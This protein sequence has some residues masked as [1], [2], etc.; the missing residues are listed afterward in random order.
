M[1]SQISLALLA[2]VL[3]A[4]LHEPAVAQQSPGDFSGQPASGQLQARPYGCYNLSQMSG[5]VPYGANGQCPPNTT[6]GYGQIENPSTQYTNLTTI[7]SS[8]APL[9]SLS[10]TGNTPSASGSTYLNY[11]LTVPLSDFATASSVS[12]LG[13]QVSQNQATSASSVAVETTRATTAEG[14]IS[15][16]LSAEVTR[17]TTSEAALGANLAAETS[18]ATVAENNLGQLIANETTAREADI[19]RVSWQFRSATASAVALSGNGFIPGKQFNLTINYGAYQGESSVAVQGAY[20]VNP[21]AYLN[22]GVASGLSGGG[23]AYRAGVTMG[24]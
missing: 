7:P 22:F 11:S 18:R 12:N 10:F 21:N 2:V 8:L 24:W 9:V 13:T 3:L 5:L 4:C 1:M 15:G 16:N 20:V 19:A 14:V 6:A 17:A 23:T